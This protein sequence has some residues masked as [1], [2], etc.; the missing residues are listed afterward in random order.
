MI[1]LM[2]NSPERAI[3]HMD[4]DSFFVSVECKRD[5]RLKGKPLII[6][7]KSA[8][9][10][11]SSCSYEA[12]RY[13][14]HS[15]MPMRLAMQLCPDAIILGGDMEAYSR[16]S[17]L[18]TDIIKE[19]SPLFEKS[20]IDEFYIDASGMD[21]FFG[22][23]KWGNELRTRIMKE[24]GLPIS[25]GLSVNKL[26]SKMATNEAKPNG[27]RWVPN[28]EEKEFIAPLPVRKIPMVGSKTARFLY[29][30]GIRTV[31]MLRE[32]PVEILEATLGTNGASLWKKAHGIDDS[33]IVPFNER[34]SIST[35]T[36]FTEDTIDLKKMK[37][38]LVAMVEKLTFKLRQEKKLTACV[39]VKIRYADFETTSRQ[40]KIPYTASDHLLIQQV[41][42]LF[43]KLYNRRLMIRLIGV[44]FSH[45]VQGHYQIHLFEDSEEDINLYQAMDRIRKK[46]GSDSLFRASGMDI[47]NRLRHN[48]NLFSSL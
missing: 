21:R 15:A 4:L 25:M 23:Q 34:K 16:E 7:G 9:G 33:P 5:S 6:G 8:R 3:I 35:E 28:G 2:G 13:G 43:D 12:R 24:S 47:N 48:N 46:Y 18:I 37:S 22:S 45:L 42:S 14:V 17:G 20:S 30:M 44:R 38:I 11:V 10:V 36:T 41:T 27:S 40:L 32:M 39:A 29:D 1:I 31:Q 26:I 19:A